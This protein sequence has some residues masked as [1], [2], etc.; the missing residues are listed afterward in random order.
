[1][2]IGIVGPCSAGKST[3]A[4]LLRNQNLVVKEIMQ[5]H[6]S[7]P[8]MWQRLSKPDVLVY[9]DVSEEVAAEREGLEKPSSWWKD[10]R[11]IRLAHA[12][13]HCNLYI[14]TTALTPEEVSDK[15]KTYLEKY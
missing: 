11:S 4:Y 15:V 13:A 2:L 6:C 3:L 14:D 1:M 10:E 9:L 8:D 7:A 12:R 5:E